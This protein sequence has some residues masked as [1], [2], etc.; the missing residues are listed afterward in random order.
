MPVD[1]LKPI[2]KNNMTKHNKNNNSKGDS[3]N[4]N[5]NSTNNHGMAVLQGDYKGYTATELPVHYTLK[6][7]S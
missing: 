1:V 4:K 2:A 5:N 3:N 6:P 7:K